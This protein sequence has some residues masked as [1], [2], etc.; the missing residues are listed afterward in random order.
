MQS[1]P[2]VLIV[3]VAITGLAFL[4]QACMLAG[5]LIAL[6]KTAKKVDEISQ[7]VKTT[8]LPV[9]H[10]T[11]DLLQKI[12]PQVISISA[13]IASIAKT[14]QG[15]T[16]EVKESVN[17]IMDRVSRQTERLDVM[18]THGLNSVEK[19][20]SALESAV[21]AP[22]RKVNGVMGRRRRR[23]FI[24]IARSLLRP[25]KMPGRRRM[26]RSMRGMKSFIPILTGI[27]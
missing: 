27:L 16:K 8:V 10:S 2:P 24:P 13:D 12:S 9:V 4:M 3:F 6:L 19:A 23:C 25:M 7:D 26:S 15:E 18:L 20:G 17:A 5:I 22:V 11:R 1:I 14:V 21:A